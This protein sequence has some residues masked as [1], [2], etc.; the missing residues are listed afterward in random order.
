MAYPSA[1]EISTSYTAQEQALG[2]GTLPGQELDVDLAAVR[3]SITAI[4]EFLKTSIRSDGRLNNGTVTSDTLAS[5]LIIGFDPPAPWTSAVAYTTRSTV[6]S[7]FGFYLCLTA[8][9][10]TDFSTDLAS[11]RWVLLADL[12]PPGGA[13]IAANNFSDVPDKAVARSTLGLGTMSTVNSGTGASDFRT[14]LQNEAFFQ[15][16]AATL[17]A[18]A[19]ITRAPGFDTFVAT[20]TSANLRALLSDESGAGAALFAGGALGTPASGVLTNC[21]GLP[22]A[23]LAAAAVRLSSEGFATPTDTEVPTAAWAR[24]YADGMLFRL[25][26]AN[27]GANNTSTQ[28][29]FPQSPTVEASSVYAFDIV[30]SLSKT[31]GTTNHFISFGFGGTA[32]LNNIFWYFDSSAFTPSTVAATFTSA[33]YYTGVTLQNITGNV[34]TAATMNWW[35]RVT[36]TV[37]I[38][39]AGTLI[40]QYSLSAAPGGAYST[41]I[42]A[43]YRLRRLGPS[44]ANTALGAW[45]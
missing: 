21:T 39:A 26:S 43:F 12:T 34:G 7:G 18:W 29:I 24:S 14:N 40:P 32:T 5:S 11:G 28:N 2:N 31:A 36:G 16:L 13:L 9:T 30:F 10:S 37:S 33:G 42:G 1:P 45:A 15:P 41:N 22:F 25:D 8:H 17:T 38:N 35:M 19:A 27:A 3:A 23:G 4:I 20:P 44:G 6:F